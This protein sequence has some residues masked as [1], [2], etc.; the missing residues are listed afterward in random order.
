MSADATTSVRERGKIER[1]QRVRQ[2]A[3][4]MFAEKGYD[5]TTTK[6]IA[7]RA[8][9][10]AGTVFVYARDKR[11][12]LMMV[13]NDQLDALTDEELD[14]AAA[15]ISLLDQIMIFFAKRYALWARNPELS[16]C[17]VRETFS[18]V[19][20]TDELGPEIL[21]F[22][23]RL[24]RH[25]AKFTA[26]IKQRQARGSLRPDLDAEMIAQMCMAIYLNELRHWLASRVLDIP[27]GLSRLRALLELALTGLEAGRPSG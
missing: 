21:R 22:L 6:E 14:D 10:G 25:T 9:V 7:E 13:M 20:D 23:H 15:E 1:R 18:Y 11:E 24:P 8:Q 2:A 19:K 5:A 4:E 17:T 3:L 27:A 26:L 16:R 12:L